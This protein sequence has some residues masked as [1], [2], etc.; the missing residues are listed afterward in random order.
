MSCSQQLTSS[1][2]VFS[3]DGLNVV[4]QILGKRGYD[5]HLTFVCSLHRQSPVPGHIKV[6]EPSTPL[7]DIVPPYVRFKVG[8]VCRNGQESGG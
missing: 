3:E 6:G 7:L 2:V 8:M 1:R 5:R 4:G